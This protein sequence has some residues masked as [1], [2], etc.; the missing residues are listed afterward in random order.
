[1]FG[2]IVV[3]PFVKS[4]SCPSLGPAML[5]AAAAES[6]YE[7]MVIDLAIEEIRWWLG[8]T[9][10]LQAPS[11]L[12]GDHD[13]NDEALREAEEA[14]FRD[15]GASHCPRRVRDCELDFDAAR[16][17]LPSWLRDLP[18]GHPAFLV[19]VRWIPGGSHVVNAAAAAYG[20]T[21]RRHLSFAALAIVP[22]ALFF[23]SVV[24][25]ITLL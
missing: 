5:R 18:A 7:V 12:T 22:R 17:R 10:L 23:A 24:H 2:L 20:V 15:L 25:G 16:Q 9:T 11:G 13:K 1:M 4:S 14:F 3:P 19:L 6:G 8:S 21:L